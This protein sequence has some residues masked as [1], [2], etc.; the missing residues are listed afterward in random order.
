MIPDHLKTTHENIRRQTTA[1]NCEQYDVGIFDREAEKRMKAGGKREPLLTQKTYTQQEL[2]DPKTIGLLRSENAKDKDIWIRP[3][4]GKS[5]LVLVDDIPRSMI[6]QLQANGLPC[7]TAI[8]TSKGNYQAWLKLHEPVTAEV[9]AS[10]Q[11]NISRTYSSDI[12]STGRDHYGR[13]AGF[14]NRKENHQDHPYAKV[15]SASGIGINSDISKGLVET[16]QRTLQA[17]K[18]TLKHEIASAP[19]ITDI[20]PDTLDAW[21]EDLHSRFTEKTDGRSDISQSSIDFSIATA[22]MDR[23]VDVDS[24][25]EALSRNSPDLDNRKPGHTQDY[26]NRT[27]LRAEEWSVAKQ[28]GIEY[29]D[30]RTMGKDQKA[31][32][33]Q[34][35]RASREKASSVIV[36]Q[37]NSG[38]IKEQQNAQRMLLQEQER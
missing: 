12:G 35:A 33:V 30:F 5:D 8:E 29:D 2:L 26:C 38:E 34:E 1:M 36:S 7:A 31:A 14:T 13:L 4:P 32:M 20:Q 25:A 18:E 19:A 21:Y 24:V 15:Y 3:A 16:T 17:Q 9:R 28:N 23:G 10:I 27:S 37:E 6:G 22:M 11:N